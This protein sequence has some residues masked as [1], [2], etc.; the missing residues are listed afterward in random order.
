[1]NLP[2][3]ES[4]EKK[5]TSG[6]RLDSV[7]GIFLLE[8]APLHWLGQLATFIRQR[9]N[10]G[11]TVTFVID[12]NPN[13]TNICDTDCHFCAF[14][15]RPKDADAY[16]LSVDDVMN[17]IDRVVKLG[18]TTILLQG[19]HNRELPLDYYVSLVRETKRRFPHLTP[20]FFSASEI[21]TMADVSGHTIEDVLLKL[22][23]A[24]QTSL[25]GGGAEILSDRV[26]KSIS[27]KKGGAEAWLSVHRAAHRLGI[28]S[29]ATMMYGHVEDSTD[30]V[31]HWEKIRLLQDE[32]K[33]QRGG[34]YFT[35]FVPWSFKPD[36]TVLKKRFPRS[37]GPLA[38]ARILAASRIFLDNFD[39]IQASW[40]SE[41]K[42]A[43]Q[44]GLLFGADDFGGTLYEEN[45][46]AEA[47]YVNTSTWEEIIR[48]IHDAGFDAQQ[49]STHY[50]KLSFYQRGQEVM[51]KDRISAMEISLRKNDPV[52]S[53]R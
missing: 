32:S 36:N 49:R 20:H 44:I 24:G 27:P 6:Q 31:E 41:G 46:H 5:I 11:K 51:T 35:A 1:V 22:K 15:R 10:P 33:S 39:H 48:M 4:I 40:F 12:A 30:I 3:T 29:T 8:E 7:D 28:V 14:F 52:G 18:A 21:T 43:G 25:P 34:G 2:T 37:Q 50:E 42:K 16:T 19:G 13:Y 45:V 17:R 38:Y 9:K 23:E 53:E 26:R 47:N